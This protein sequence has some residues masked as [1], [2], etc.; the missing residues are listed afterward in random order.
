MNTS[1]LLLADGFEEI[2]ALGTLDILRRAGMQVTS[3]SINPTATVTGAHGITVEADMV[4]A[5]EMPA[6][7]WV[8][9]P[10][11]MPGA[12]NLAES[13]AVRRLIE[14]QS[15]QQGYIAAI[16]AAPAVVL[17]PMGVLDGRRATC[18]PGFEQACYNASLKGDRV[19]VDGTVITA[20]G[21]GCTFDFALTIVRTVLGSDKADEVAAGMLLK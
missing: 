8:I 12:S 21:P 16:C 9:L 15:L 17:A 1:Y 19:A 7:D 5:D 6:A 11:G 3:V 4:I 13:E 18:Y 2:E 20:A 10:G 14:R